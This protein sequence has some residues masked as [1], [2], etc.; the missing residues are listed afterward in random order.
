ML[1]NNK[2]EFANPCFYRMSQINEEVDDADFSDEDEMDTMTHLSGE[3]PL[4]TKYAF[5]QD[6]T[7]ALIKL[8]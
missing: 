3:Q 5:D 8:Y 4:A 2:P 6:N 1:T 7:N